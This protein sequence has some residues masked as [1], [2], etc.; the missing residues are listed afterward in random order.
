MAMAA[1]CRLILL[2]FFTLFPLGGDSG[3]RGPPWL[4]NRPKLR[5]NLALIPVISRT[6]LRRRGHRAVGGSPGARK[7]VTV[8]ARR[9]PGRPPGYS[10][11]D[12]LNLSNSKGLHSWQRWNS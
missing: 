5:F 4:K 2:G 1:D 8:F 3:V 7:R 6:C 12:P 11:G 9:K 10:L